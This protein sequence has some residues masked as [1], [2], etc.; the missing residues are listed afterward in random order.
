[1]QRQEYNQSLVIIRHL[2]LDVFASQTTDS[3]VSTCSTSK[4]YFM[5]CMDIRIFGSTECLICQLNTAM[6]QTESFQLSNL[7][8]LFDKATC[9]PLGGKQDCS[10]L[11]CA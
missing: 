1:M 4:V 10:T 2:S 3:N 7:V 8:C 11:I 6:S 9:Y 5:Q